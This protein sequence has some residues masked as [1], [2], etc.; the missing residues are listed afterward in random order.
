M[1]ENIVPSNTSYDYYDDPLFLSHPD[2]PT[3]SLSTFPFDGHDFMGW[4]REIL[5]GLATKNKLGFIDG[6]VPKPPATDKRY[7]QWVRCDFMTMRWISNSLE[8]PLKESLKYV[9][10]S[11]ELWSELLERY[12]QANAIEIYQLTKELG[13]VVHDNLSLVEYYGKLKNLWETL[14]CL[15]PLPVCSCGKI[16]L[17]T[18]TLMRRMVERDN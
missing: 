2:Q 9:R 1:P 15:D 12:G 14:D 3:A 13:A 4:K 18:C 11:K 17:C 8:K 16:D 7:N 5:M 6:S 10:S